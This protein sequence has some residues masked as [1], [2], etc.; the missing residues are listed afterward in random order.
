VTDSAIE[1]TGG[2]LRDRAAG[3]RLGTARLRGIAWPLVVAAMVFDFVVV[4]WGRAFS[5]DT[6]IT[7]TAGRFIAQHGLPHTDSLSLAAHGRPWID[8]QW[9]A[10]VAYYHAWLLGGNAAVSAL[11]ALAIGTAAAILAALLL[12]RGTPPML[13]LA[14]VLSG[15]LLELLFFAETRAQSFAYPLFAGLLFLIFDDLDRDRFDRRLLLALP[16]LVLWANVHGSVLMG[17]GMFAAVCGWR[18]LASMRRGRRPDAARYLALA[19]AAVLMPLVTPYGGDIIGYY[20][21]L[22]TDPALQV[23]AEWQP[24]S[25]ALSDLPYALVGLAGLATIAYAAGRGVRLPGVQIAG[26]AVLGLLGAYTV[27]YQV[28]FTLAAAPVLAQ[29]LTELRADRPAGQPFGGRLARPCAAALIAATIG[30]IAFVAS[31]HPAQ[32]TKAVSTTAVDG[33]ARYALA[34]P[35]SRVLADD[36]TGSA[37]LWEYPQLAGRVGYDSRTEIYQPSGFLAFAHYLSVAGTDWMRPAH[38]YNVLSVTCD[39]HPTLCPALAAL[40]AWRVVA[41]SD[42][43][44]VFV[45]RGA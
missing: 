1:R 7:L 34:H 30:A 15:P 35:G 39:Y 40:P 3:Q 12:R 25:F 37:I 4:A 17:A 43:G 8:Q 21:R 29:V 16:L 42:G 6:W 13:M 22:L 2:G 24:G 19:G 28:W 23:I 27:R 32:Y 41:K 5:S 18:S 36:V 11:S 14:L 20:H 45:R 26:L 38:G 10:Q 44:M 9:L 31:S 33:A